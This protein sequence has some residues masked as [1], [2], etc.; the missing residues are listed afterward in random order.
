M[1][2][3]IAVGKIA[4]VAAVT[5]SDAV[6]RFHLPLLPLLPS[7]CNSALQLENQ[8]VSAFMGALDVD[9]PNQH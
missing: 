3:C 4:A 9:I 2:L 6:C 5:T 7:K 8:V 1:L